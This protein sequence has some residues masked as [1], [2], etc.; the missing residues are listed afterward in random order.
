MRGVLSQPMPALCAVA[1]LVAFSQAS[2]PP[3]R[4]EAGDRI[5]VVVV[6]DATYSGEYIVLT[7]GSVT[8][9]G[10][11]RLILAGKTVDQARQAITTALSKILRSPTV[12]VVIEEQKKKFVFVTSVEGVAPGPIEFD[13][14][15]DVRK[16]ITGVTVP[17]DSSTYI[18]RLFRA[19]QSIGQAPLDIVL[20]GGEFGSTP[21]EPNDVV[22]IS[23]AD[24]YRIYVTGRVGQP[25]EMRVL[26]GIDVRQAIAMAGGTSAHLEG[27]ISFRVFVR[28]GPQLIEVSTQADAPPFIL[29]PGD[30]VVVEAPSQIKVSVGGEVQSP[31]EHVVRDQSELLAAIQKSGGVNQAGTLSNVLVIRSGESYVLNLSPIQA[32]GTVPSFPLQD[33]DLVFVRR[34]EDRL[35]V[36]GFAV[37]PGP[38]LMEP[39]REYRL[40]DAVAEAGGASSRG[41]LHRV[42]LGRRNPETGK[43]EV[44]EYR[45]AAFL[46]DGD[47]TQ[48][49]ELEP[50]DVVMVGEPKGLTTAAIGQ[51]ISNAL[52]LDTLLR[53]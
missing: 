49:P 28:R 40:A 10:F 25:G 33:G 21:L 53:R 17:Q 51:V 34:N 14:A 48:N 24:R 26:A 4:I 15:L 20:A 8:G 41:T 5:R 2:D 35:I 16:V 23:E 45:L 18:V 42:Y 13:P 37:K 36:L 32:G 39:H 19:G 3:A 11:G 22:T 44:T 12:S 7:D 43:V 1:L 47:V 31:G 30:T 9:V 6:E 50:G 29:E 27:E 46:K 38:I 52:L